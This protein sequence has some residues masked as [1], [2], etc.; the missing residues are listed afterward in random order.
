MSQLYLI[1][2][3]KNGIIIDGVLHELKESK[4]DDCSKCSLYNLCQDEFKNNC[5]CWINLIKPYYHDYG[6][7]K[8]RW[9]LKVK[10]ICYGIESETTLMFDSKS[11]ALNV[12]KGY[13]FLA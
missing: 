9:W 13:M 7:G 10:A 12:C 11:D 3:I 1:M 4:R 5:L 2:E 8:F 6:S